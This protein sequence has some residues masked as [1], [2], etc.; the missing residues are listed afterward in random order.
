MIH[1]QHKKTFFIIGG[2]G[3]IGFHLT[4]KLL[5]LGHNVIIY[6]AFINYIHPS[7]SNYFQCLNYRLKKLDKEVKIIRGDIRH[8]HILEKTIKDISPNI[9]INLAAIPIATTSNIFIEEAI[10][11]NVGG[12]TNILDCLRALG[13][14]DR[15]VNISSSYIYGDFSYTPADENHPKSPIDIY[16][17][18]KYAAEILTESYCRKF[19]IDYT[20]IRPSAVYG[21]TD[22]NYR[23]SQIFVENAFNG[24][25]LLLN[26]GGMSS[27]DFT[28]V[29][30]TASGIALAALSP[31]GINE[32][33]NITR[34]EAVTLKAFS[35]IIQEYFPEAS[36]EESP[37]TERRP[38]RGALCI[39]KA[40]KLLGYRPKFNFQSGIE[41]YFNFYQNEF[42][43]KE[44]HYND[45]HPSM[46]SRYWGK[47][48]FSSDRSDQVR[49]D[50]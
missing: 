24:M 43:F 9:I 45:R 31:N 18:S 11:I 6:D 23:V 12:T 42:L 8:K 20:I 39:K 25:P 50:D 27:L 10:E 2:A 34:G 30:D 15:F 37:A 48:N 46:H 26:N 28:Y 35:E 7:K 3:F 19:E 4:N 36:V 41:Q 38:E 49:M 5:S 16:G 14:V 32:V 33:F 47:R 13:N 29:E 22:A 44:D 40:Q 17:G 21:P 1:S